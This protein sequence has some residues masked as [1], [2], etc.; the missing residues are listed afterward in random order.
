MSHYSEDFRIERNRLEEEIQKLIEA[1]EETTGFA[2][3]DIKDVGRFNLYDDRRGARYHRIKV[4]IN[5]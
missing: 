1:F 4:S 5:I 3:T 2:V